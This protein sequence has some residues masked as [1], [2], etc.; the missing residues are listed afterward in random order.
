LEKKKSKQ[1]IFK[2]WETQKGGKQK[3]GAGIRGQFTRETVN[4]LNT[5]GPK[6]PVCKLGFGVKKKKKR[7][8]GPKGIGPDVVW[9]SSRGR[10]ERGGGKK[11]LGWEFRTLK[12]KRVLWKHRLKQKDTGKAKKQNRGRNCSRMKKGFSS[13]APHES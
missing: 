4:Q 3:G 9:E 8:T 12:G 6:K 1:V 11:W 5:R 2:W 7:R 13:Q 10:Y